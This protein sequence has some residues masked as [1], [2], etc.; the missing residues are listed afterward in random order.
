MRIL[1]LLSVWVFC[2]VWDQCPTGE[3]VEIPWRVDNFWPHKRPSPT[4]ILC[5]RL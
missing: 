1:N 4:L 2:A 5:N 3:I